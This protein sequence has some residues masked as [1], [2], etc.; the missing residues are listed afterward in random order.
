[1]KAGRAALAAS[2]RYKDTKMHLQRRPVAFEPEETVEESGGKVLIF[3]RNLIVEQPEVGVFTSL[4]NKQFVY[5]AL[6]AVGSIGPVYLRSR[7]RLY[8]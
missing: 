8:D 2:E 7:R 3:Y 4:F 6:F 1:L 5:A